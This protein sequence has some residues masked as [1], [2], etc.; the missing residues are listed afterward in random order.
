MKGK[1]RKRALTFVTAFLAGLLMSH[2]IVELASD[3]AGATTVYADSSNV[4]TFSN[5]IVEA[6]ESNLVYAEIF[7]TGTPGST[8]TVTYRSTSGTAIENV[9]YVGVYN[10]AE[11]KIDDSGGV[12]YTIAIKCLD[13]ANTRE[14]LRVYNGDNNNGRYFNLYI[15]DAN[16]ATIGTAN[17]CKCYLSYNYRVNAT[18]GAGDPILGGEVAYL[19]DY[20]DMQA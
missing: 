4:V 13:D 3:L 19:D 6:N 16:N 7:V 5:T 2:G 18:V 1:W 12:G 8:V 10:T 20:K 15:V 11:L 9:D 14:K 17:R